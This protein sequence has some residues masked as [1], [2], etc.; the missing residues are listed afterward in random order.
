MKKLINL[1]FIFC[2]QLVPAKAQWV[3]IPDNNFVNKL[4]Q[5]YPSCMNGNQLDT[6]CTPLT[7]EDSLQIENLPIINFE[8]IQYFDSL[9]YLRLYSTSTTSFPSLPNHLDRLEWEFMPMSSLPILPNTLKTLICKY[10]NNFSAPLSSLPT[11]PIGLKTL[12][13]TNNN[14]L[15]TLSSLPNSLEYLRCNNNEL[16]ILP[17]LPGSL[18]KLYCDDNALS[19]LP[20][21]PNGLQKLSC[22]KNGL[23]TLPA[24]PNS[25]L[26]LNCNQTY[27]NN[28]PTLNS[29]LDSLACYDNNLTSLPVLPSGLKRLY[30]GDNQLSNFPILPDSLLI[31]FC[32]LNPIAS[33]PSWP[34]SLI[35]LECGYSQLTSLPP[36]PGNLKKLF[37]HWNQLTSLPTLPNSLKY[38]YCNNNSITA[39]PSL[40]DSLTWLDC[41]NNQLTSLPTLNSSLTTLICNFNQLSSLPTLPNQLWQLECANNQ[42]TSLPAIPSSLI[43]LYCAYNQLT[44]IPQVPSSMWVYDIRYNNINCV[45][46]LP[47]VS[48][49][50]LP[51]AQISNTLLTCVPNQTNYSLGLPLCIDSDPVN[52]PSNC[53]SNVNISGFVYTDIDN[54][55]TYSAGDLGSLNIPIK[56]FDSLDNQIAQ[57]YTSGGT[58]G[59]SVSQPGQYK[60][61]I[62]VTNLSYSLGCG[63]ADSIMVNLVSISNSINGSH[64]P[65]YCNEGFDTKIQ[66]VTS[67]GWVFPGQIH[68]LKTNVTNNEAWNNI[69]CDSIIYS[70]TVTIEL[71]GPVSYF[72]PDINAL[73]P[74]VNGNIFTYTISDFSN[75]TA[76]SFGLQLMT[77]TFAQA[78]TP[79]CAHLT[80]ITNP[81]DADTINNEYDFCYNVVNSYD[82]NMKEV[83]PVNVLPG[84]DDWFTYTIHFQNTGN[85]P[86]FKIRLRDTLDANLDI[87][88]F[89]IRGYS[90]PA[91]VSI[92]GNILTVRFNNI[93]LPDSTTD[94][95]G[96][97]GYF[98][99][100]MKPLPNLPLGTQIENTAY[101]YFDYNAPIITNT[102]QNNFQLVTDLKSIDAKE[103]NFV[104][105]PNPS[106]GIYFFKDNR[107][108]QSIEVYNM[109]GELILSQGSAKQINLQ[110]FPKGIYVVK[111]NGAYVKRLVKE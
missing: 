60:V 79:V 43:Q 95:E 17:A 68:T 98:Q 28:L 61:K 58:Y 96:S 9:K 65:I 59:F 31:F 51:W 89:E 107:N 47:Y 50:N 83:Y 100:R 35:E 91:N 87:N 82:P 11:L 16:S 44:F 76:N 99:Y 63:Q 10:N 41:K 8:G 21:L 104:I 105:Y 12:V 101:I 39:L 84:Y 109:M 111:I 48:N 64:F 5:L 49:N 108:L 33:F 88:T 70:G 45:T 62:P 57:Y 103:S 1:F 92:N 2:L 106:S 94:Y 110:A 72:S 15:T 78:G 30:C 20:A 67:S 46:N 18:L 38:L 69:I 93:M 6:T 81:T 56:L 4:T 77:D 29:S 23:G 52:N 53:A 86:A 3:T 22:S 26:M 36:L 42:I 73:T 102:T 7:N 66:S 14:Q 80:L 32:G 37:C 34:I 24:L 74:Q 85:A 54:N 27:L 25:L 19:D 55:C 90:H 40:N 75:L 13:C 71:T 97:M